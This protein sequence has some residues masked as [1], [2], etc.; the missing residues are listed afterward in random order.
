MSEA[1]HGHDEKAMVAEFLQNTVLPAF[2]E[3]KRELEA[4]GATVTVRTVPQGSEGYGVITVVHVGRG[5]FRYEMGVGVPPGTDR[6]SGCWR[7]ID[8][9]D[10]KAHECP[11][12]AT[13]ADRIVDDFVEQYSQDQARRGMSVSWAS[14]VVTDGG[15]H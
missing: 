11:F 6:A 13:T 2:Q 15:P 1:L 8:T 9:S 5:R 4:H 7:Q 3:I 10:G 12:I 14:R